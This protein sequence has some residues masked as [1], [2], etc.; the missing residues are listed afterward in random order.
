MNDFT[1]NFGSIVRC[2]DEQ[3]GKLAKV[4]FNPENWQVT[5]LIVEEGF[6]LKKARIFPISVVDWATAEE[7][8]ISVH[9]DELSSYP[10]YRE[11]VV[12]KIPEGSAAEPALIQGSPYGLATSSPI[13]PMVREVM[14]EGVA[15][16]LARIDKNTHLEAVDAT[17]GTIRGLTIVPENGLITGFLV[18]K[19]TIFAEEFLLSTSIVRRISSKGVFVNM[20]KDE[21]SELIEHDEAREQYW[22]RMPTYERIEIDTYEPATAH[23]HDSHGSILTDDSAL[24]AVIVDALMDDP[25]TADAVIEVINERGTVT[26]QGVVEDPE[27]RITAEEIARDYPGV[28]TVTNELAVNPQ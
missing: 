1:F 11:I 10:E 16:H 23:A 24:A 28:I 17:V 13:V 9:E 12:E 2:F 26:L 8:S 20:T 6:L 7:I 18:H 19:G 5:N 3:C 27:T 21:L 15:D 25:R 22:E 14:V 4:I